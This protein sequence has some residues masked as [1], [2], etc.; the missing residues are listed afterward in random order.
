MKK[1]ICYL[2]SVLI[3][4][5]GFLGRVNADD[6]KELSRKYVAD[7]KSYFVIDKRSKNVLDDKVIKE[8]KDPTVH[9]PNIVSYY[10]V[11][12][13][14]KSYGSKNI[15]ELAAIMGTQARSV[16]GL[17]DPVFL[18]TTEDDEAVKQEEKWWDLLYACSNSK[19]S[20]EDSLKKLLGIESIYNYSIYTS[21]LDSD[22]T[23][24]NSGLWS[25]FVQ[26]FTFG[27]STKC[28]NYR[29]E[30]VEEEN[31]VYT[32]RIYSYYSNKIEEL[33]T[34][35]KDLGNNIYK[36]EYD[37]TINTMKSLCNQAMSSADYDDPCIVN[38][39]GLSKDKKE[40]DKVF[41]PDTPEKTCG[42]SNKLISW[43]LNIIRWVKYIIPAIV[44]IFG[45]LDFIKAI[46][47]DKDDEMKKAQGRFIKRLIAA[48]LIFIVPFIIEFVLDK[49]GFEV[50]S[51]GIIRELD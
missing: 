16:Y 51:C 24:I 9:N 39:L 5:V 10:T 33:K 32:C 46:G 4:F 30:G 3:I 41:Y 49:M 22:Q 28:Q 29:V 31:K 36:K 37:N 35:Y 7:D 1:N 40:W 25:D 20:I 47:S 34:K 13:Y 6:D 23:S 42:F 18:F 48:A 15:F 26:H 12:Y 14:F 17:G 38:C 44:I 21:P 19:Y 11:Q 27:E 50:S 45:I 43:V 2:L 8:P